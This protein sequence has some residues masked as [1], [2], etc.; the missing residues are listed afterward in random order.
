MQFVGIYGFIFF[1]SGWTSFRKVPNDGSNKYEDIRQ[2]V[3]NYSYVALALVL[4]MQFATKFGVAGMPHMFV[5]EVFP[6]KYA[7]STHIEFIHTYS[8]SIW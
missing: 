6:L 3:G 2:I 1:P 5:S 4:T 7:L 8:G